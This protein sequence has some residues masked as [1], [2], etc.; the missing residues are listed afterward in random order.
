[1]DACGTK[2][3]LDGAT[4]EGPFLPV[5]FHW[6]SP[7]P[8]LRPQAWQCP[9]PSLLRF[10]YFSSLRLPFFRTIPCLP[11]WMLHS[12]DWSLFAWLVLVCPPKR[13]AE[14]VTPPWSAFQFG[15]VCSLLTFHGIQPLGESE[16]SWLWRT[17]CCGNFQHAGSRISLL[18]SSIKILVLVMY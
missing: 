14:R 6:K 10:W 17:V 18:W 15:V 11:C 8:Q 7:W 16:G 9:P 5:Q 13:Y 12:Q 2:E 3:R 4:N 1:V